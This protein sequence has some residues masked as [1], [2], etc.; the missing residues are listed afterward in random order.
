MLIM[1]VSERKYKPDINR[2]ITI[3]V[4]GQQFVVTSKTLLKHPQTRLGQLAAE[5]ESQHFFE[6]D[7]DVFKEILK[8]YWTDKLHCP[9]NICIDDFLSHLEFWGVD[10]KYISDCCSTGLDEENSLERQFKYFDDVIAPTS[11]ARPNCCH[12]LRD[13]IWCM[14]TLPG[15]SETRWTV[16]AKVWAVFYLTM[17]IYGSLLH[18]VIS[19]YRAQVY[20]EIQSEIQATNNSTPAYCDDFLIDFA[21]NYGYLEYDTQR[22]VL[23]TFF[24]IEIII[25][26]I[27]CPQKRRFFKSVNLLDTIIALAELT[28]MLY[29]LVLKYGLGPSGHENENRC[30]LAIYWSEL[31]VIFSTF[32]LFRL[33]SYAT[34]YRLVR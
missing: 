8:F 12:N 30:L 16:A 21:Q 15:W 5:N 10:A 22:L 33:L 23:C 31:M 18:A 13:N 26:F 24:T 1:E 7:P 20:T 19:L 32:R 29:I 14:L 34:V 11:K 6:S 27:C 4:C 9:R 28:L 25:R 17:T 3:V 2:K